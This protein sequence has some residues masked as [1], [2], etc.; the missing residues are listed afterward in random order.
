L[1]DLLSVQVRFMMPLLCAH[2]VIVSADSTIQPMSIESQC[3]IDVRLIIIHFINQ[4]ECFRCCHV[5]PARNPGN[6]GVSR[7]IVASDKEYCRILLGGFKQVMH[8][9]CLSDLLIVSLIKLTGAEH[10]LKRRVPLVTSWCCNGLHSAVGALQLI[11]SR[12]SPTATLPSKDS[13]DSLSKS[14]SS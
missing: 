12:T 5:S 9:V 8:F 1:I 14:V 7:V 10:G 4:S 3:D 11:F 2:M 6:S 13:T